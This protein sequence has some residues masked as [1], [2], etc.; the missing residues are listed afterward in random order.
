MRGGHLFTTRTSRGKEV[1]VTGFAITAWTPTE[2]GSL[3]REME[4]RQGRACSQSA[5]KQ[6]SARGACWRVGLT[7]S[8]AVREHRREQDGPRSW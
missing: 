1:V 7:G 3:L 5:R 6:R 8:E 2:F 4:S